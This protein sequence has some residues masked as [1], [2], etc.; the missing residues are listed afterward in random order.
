MHLLLLVVLVVAEEGQQYP[1]VEAEVGQQ[2]VAEE[3]LLDSMCSL[4]LGCRPSPSSSLPEP[5]SAFLVRCCILQ[6]G[7]EKVDGC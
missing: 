2:E 3:L 1:W 6:V 5:S 4:G 7:K